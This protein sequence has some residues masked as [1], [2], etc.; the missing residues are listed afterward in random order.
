MNPAADF[1]E[2]WLAAID[3]QRRGAPRADG[4]PEAAQPGFAVYANTGLQ[5]CISALGAAFPSVAHWLGGPW[6]LPLAIRYAREHPPTDSRLFLYGESFPEFLAACEPGSDW[7]YLHHLARLDRL[8]TQA[9]G[10]A[11]AET[12]DVQRWAAQAPAALAASP[13]RLAPSTRWHCSDTLP[14]WSL[15]SAARWGEHDRA[16]PRWSGQAVL[17]TRPGDDVLCC[18]IDATGCALLQAFEAGLPFEQAIEA[19]RLST[20]DADVQTALAKLFAQGAFALRPDHLL[21]DES[22]T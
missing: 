11:D 12:L 16:L 15:W 6:F 1:H 21:H 13:L 18:E 22:M 4:P 17:L 19:A 8:W 20:P 9:H 7:P 2:R 5:A 3:G 10:A 14:V